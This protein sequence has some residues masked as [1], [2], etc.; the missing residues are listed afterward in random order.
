MTALFQP[1]E[2]RAVIDRAYSRSSS[3]LSFPSLPSCHI[4]LRAGRNPFMKYL[5]FVAFAASLMLSVHIMGGQQPQAPGGQQPAAGAAPQD[6]AARG[7]GRG[8][9]GGGGARGTP[10]GDGPFDVGEGENKVHVT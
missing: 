9:G 8:R 1:H 3:Q 5:P 10:L 2:K 7:G 4:L 6:G